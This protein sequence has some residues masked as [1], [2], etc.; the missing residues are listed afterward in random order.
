MPLFESNDARQRRL[1]LRAMQQEIHTSL[2]LNER[3]TTSAK[4]SYQR[5]IELHHQAE[6][7]AEELLP[8]YLTQTKQESWLTDEL[9][10]RGILQP[11]SHASPA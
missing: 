6:L 5:T 8:Q 3:R 9:H 4:V 11:T 7:L 2:M 1:A 10:R